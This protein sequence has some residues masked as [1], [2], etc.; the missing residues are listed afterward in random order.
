MAVLWLP[1]IRRVVRADA[2]GRQRATL[3][4]DEA[5]AIIYTDRW[6][7]G[8]M[9]WLDDGVLESA[10][11]RIRPFETID[12]REFEAGALVYVDHGI[13][14]LWVAAGQYDPPALFE[15]VPDHLEV[16]WQEQA[17]TLYRVGVPANG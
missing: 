5:E 12:P 13:R 10:S 3:Q 16:I 15:I 1:E 7:A 11:D 6:T 17:V 14:D 2:L 9:V 8:N 4:I